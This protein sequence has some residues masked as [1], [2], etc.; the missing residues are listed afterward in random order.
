MMFLRISKPLRFVS[1]N[2][3]KA[4]PTIFFS[5][6]FSI[7][8]PQERFR[9]PPNFLA[10][11]PHVNSKHRES[12]VDFL[13]QMHRHIS[14]AF[15]QSLQLETLFLA[16]SIL[17]RFLS[18]KVIAFEKLNLIA[19]SCF[20]V[21]SKVEETYYP[22]IDQLLRFVPRLGKKDDVLLS[23]RLILNE[24]RYTLGAPTPVTFLKRYA[25]AA[26]ADSSIGMAAR[27]ICEFSLM[28][29]TVVGG[30]PPSMIAACSIAH[31]LRVTSHAP[32][33]AT[34]Q[35]YTGYSYDELR[36]CLVEMRELV[37]SAPTM[38]AQTIY[39]KYAEPKYLKAA[40]QATQRI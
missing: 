22:S 8:N 9:L 3:Y 31:A 26:F 23:E 15:E 39:K 4:P 5:Y 35:H 33:S 18:R 10:K 11:Q 30:I 12:C 27:F 24:L 16:V 32:W 20:F 14:Q 7:V 34:L 2:W 28:S 6:F 17:D 1:S 38:R 13:V 40:V 19:V 21:A 25:K 36:P 37:K 29:D